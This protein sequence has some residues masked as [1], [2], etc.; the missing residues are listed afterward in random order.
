[1]GSLI[2]V[3]NKYNNGGP[4]TKLDTI[5]IFKILTEMPLGQSHLMT[6]RTDFVYAKF[7]GNIQYH[8]TNSKRNFSLSLFYNI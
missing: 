5:K 4:L 2:L 6:I 3:I 7:R 8:F 1:M